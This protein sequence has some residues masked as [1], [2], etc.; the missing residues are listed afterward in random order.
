MA[1]TPDGDIACT[2]RPTAAAARRWRGDESNEELKYGDKEFSARDADNTDYSVYQLEPA[3]PAHQGSRRRT[4]N[5]FRWFQKRLPMVED[6]SNEESEYGD[7]ELYIRD[8]DSSDYFVNHS[9]QLAALTFYGKDTWLPPA[10]GHSWR[11]TWRPTTFLWTLMTA[12]RS[13]S[14]LATRGTGVR[15]RIA[16]FPM[17]SRV[18]DG[19]ATSVVRGG[20]Q[21][22]LIDRRSAW[23]GRVRRLRR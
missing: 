16:C 17:H 23:S 3:G 20:C 22:P 4:A 21:V 6:D 2:T 14:G 10:G 1:S 15:C 11:P 13:S 8:T 7:K 19:W 12:T 9:L 5:T 18:H